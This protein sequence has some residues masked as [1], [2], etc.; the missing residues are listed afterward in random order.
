MVPRFIKAS[1]YVL[2]LVVAYGLGT[3]VGQQSPP[4][5]T[6]GLTIEKTITNDLGNEIEGMQGRQLR[7]RILK[8]E[9]NGVIGIHSHKDRPGVAY[10][11][12]GTLTEHREGG[13]SKNHPKGE[14]LSGG[15]DTMHWEENKEKTPVVLIV[16]DIIKP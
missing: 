4:K 2:A 12:E 16:A 10:V 3:A 5:E 11:L 6:K 13:A 15:K 1:A 8:L 7:L 9:P 14:M